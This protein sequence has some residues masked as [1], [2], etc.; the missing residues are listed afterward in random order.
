MTPEA[1][2][3]H[4][5]SGEVIPGRFS[6]T[7]LDPRQFLAAYHLGVLSTEL[8]LARAGSMP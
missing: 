6:D 4:R 5:P 1:G 3:S 7:P 8:A 2:A